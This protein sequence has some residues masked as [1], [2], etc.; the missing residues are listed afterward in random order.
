M[1]LGALTWQ[2]GYDTIYAYTDIRDDE[3]LG[4]RSTA[5]RFGSNGIYWLSGFY[6]ASIILWMMAGYWMEMSWAY[7]VVMLAVAAH[8]FWQLYRFDLNRPDVSFSL[9]RANMMTG[10]LLIIAALAGAYIA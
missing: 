8:L 10:I 7:Q 4:L 2:I 3:R 1:W 5:R 9:F 6:I